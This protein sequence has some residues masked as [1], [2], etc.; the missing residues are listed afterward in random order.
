MGD[1][2][3]Q[4]PRKTRA[5][6]IS[7]VLA[8]V[9]SLVASAS[10]AFAIATIRHVERTVEKIQTDEKCTSQDCLPITPQCLE[11]RCVFLI[12]GSDSRKG[13]PKKFGTTKN[14]PGQRSDTILLVQVDAR[15]NRTVVLSVPRDLRVDIPGHGVGKINTA[16]NY[17][18]NTM[19]RT[20]EK[21]TGLAVNHYVDVNFLGF[22][23]VVNGLGGVPICVDKAMVDALAGLNLPH[24]GCYNMRG[25]QA[26]AFVRARHVEGDAIPDFS[27]I[28]RQQQFMRALITK[29][30]SA[31]ALLHITDFIK[32][33][34]HNLRMDANLNLYALQDLTRKLAELGQSGVAFRIVPSVPVA[35]NDVDYVQLIQPQAGLLFA[36]LRRGIRPGNLGLTTVLT[37]ISPANV[38]VQVLDAG[39]NGAAQNVVNFLMK[40][41]FVVFPVA[42][43]PPGLTTSAILW[44]GDSSQEKEVVASYLTLVPPR[45]DTRHTKGATVTVVI[46]PD[47]Q[48]IEGI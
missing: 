21:L 44:N 31:G 46:A 33:V 16:F 30:L 15:H 37:R 43:A 24:P 20:V 12:L 29:V 34:Q 25:Q 41:G 39:S 40:A 42:P 17:G 5:R 18:P 27:R 4:R 45:R 2:A 26:L 19:V 3:S 38:R 28:A 11:Q 9:L 8:G 10:A 13:V 14:S 6:T 22:E 36:R 35:I 23:G 7:L 32:A 1:D 47:F 48:G